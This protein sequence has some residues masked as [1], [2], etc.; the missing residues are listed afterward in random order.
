MT[1]SVKTPI[2]PETSL[3][4]GVPGRRLL[5]GLGVLYLLLFVA[6]MATGADRAPDDDPAALIADYDVGRTA[7]QVITYTGMVAAAVLVFFGAALRSVLVSRAGRWTADAAFIGFVTMGWTIASFSVSSLGLFRAVESGDARVVRALNIID[8][9]NFPPAM[10][11]LMCAMIG[12]GATALAHKALPAWL[13][14][15]SIVLGCMAPLGP[16]GFAPFVLFPVW[17]VLVASLVRYSHT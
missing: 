9:S 10:V 17:I 4:R 11:G 16:A 8:T 13:C 5:V 3:D 2:R 7:V 15:T 14:W 12:V 6:L 1:A